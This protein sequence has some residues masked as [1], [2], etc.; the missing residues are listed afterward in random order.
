MSTNYYVIENHCEC[1]NRY[2]EAYHI[3]KS[4]YG[5]A[6]TFRGYRQKDLTSWQ[7]WKEFL[8]D[9]KIKDEFGEDVNYAWFVEYVEG[10]KS[11]NYVREDGHKNLYHNEQ[12]R[13]DKYPWSNIGPQSLWFNPEYDWDD[14]Q[15]YSF[16]TREFS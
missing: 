12:G 1:C 14:P 16:G 5:W 2:E 6:F 11:P 4:S 13:I 15:G 3:G 10:Y 7:A 8:K 9:K